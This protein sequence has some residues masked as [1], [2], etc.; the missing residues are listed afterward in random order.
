[1]IENFLLT[2]VLRMALSELNSV[3]ARLISSVFACY[4]ARFLMGMV[5]GKI[6]V[7]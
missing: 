1:M 5:V 7:N 6:F 2:L 3:I 4:S